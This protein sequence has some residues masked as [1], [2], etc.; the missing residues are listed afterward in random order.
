[1]HP[2]PTDLKITLVPLFHVPGV[3]EQ[4]KILVMVSINVAI[5]FL[6]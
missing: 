1:M 6:G 3:Q 5:L 2:D 4:G